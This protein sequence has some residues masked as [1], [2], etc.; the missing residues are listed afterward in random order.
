MNKEMNSI[1]YTYVDELGNSSS[2]DVMVEYLTTNQFSGNA[3]TNIDESTF[4]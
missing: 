4:L 2:Y 1:N 3:N